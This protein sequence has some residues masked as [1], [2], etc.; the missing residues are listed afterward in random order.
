MKTLQQFSEREEDYHLYRTR[1]DAI[2]V[3]LT[4]E[5]DKAKA[6]ELRDI[7]LKEAAEAKEA[8]AQAKKEAV[9]E[10]KKGFF[11]GFFS[12]RK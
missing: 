9:Q 12:K 11:S 1:Q 5:A 10:K 8:T 7:A 6:M 2:R 3:Q 4:Q